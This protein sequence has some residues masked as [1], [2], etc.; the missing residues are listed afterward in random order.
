MKIGDIVMSTKTRP[1]E[2]ARVISADISNRIDKTGKKYVSTLYVAKY[3]DGSLL[4]F[5]G[6]QVNKSVFKVMESDGQM[7][8]SDFYNMDICEEIK[9]EEE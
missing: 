1:Y 6:Q 3:A 4:E 9:K 2:N 7:C 8:L 5:R